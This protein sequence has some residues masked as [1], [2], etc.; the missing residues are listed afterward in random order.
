MI[1]S[2]I[3][4]PRPASPTANQ[5][6]MYNSMFLLYYKFKKIL[7]YSFPCAILTNIATSNGNTKACI[8]VTN[9]P[10]AYNINGAITGKST[11]AIFCVNEFT[12]TTS[13]H[14]SIP[15]ASIFPYNLAVS[16]STLA[17]IPTI[18]NKPTNSDMIMS[19]N[20]TTTLAG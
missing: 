11:D 17:N 7:F 18:S 19:N 12:Q 2:P 1:P 14:N 3:P 4:T 6:P 8:T 13:S 15:Q 16:D 9:S 5:A 20:L 10:C